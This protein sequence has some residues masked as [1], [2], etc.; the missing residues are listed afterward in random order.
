VGLTQKLNTALDTLLDTLTREAEKSK[1]RAKDFDTLAREEAKVKKRAKH[2]EKAYEEAKYEIECLRTSVVKGAEK[3]DDRL[4]RFVVEEKA[5][6]VAENAIYNER[7]LK[8]N[9]LE[10]W[11]ESK[12][13][14]EV[15]KKR[16]EGL[17]DELIVE[18]R[19]NSGEFIPTKEEIEDVYEDQE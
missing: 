2:F 1:K 10:Y 11:K 9:A 8:N 14:I 6:E 5:R 18:R 4:R 12:A 19:K 7:H 15:L 17:E 3:A 13:E 16:I